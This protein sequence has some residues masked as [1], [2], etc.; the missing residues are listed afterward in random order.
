MRFIAYALLS[1]LICSVA[2]V[3]AASLVTPTE[4]DGHND[5][6]FLFGHWHTHYRI[7]RHRL[8]HDNTWDQ[9]DGDATITAFWDH[10]GNLEVGTLRCPPPRGYVDSMTLRT[11]SADTHQWSLYW[12]TKKIGLSTSPQVGHFDNHGV[13]N[14]YDNDTFN[15]KPIAIRYHWETLK[16]LPHFE[17]A[18]SDDDGKTWETNWICDYTHA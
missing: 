9:C 6:N 13:G 15:G 14:F 16:G 8:T 12:G 10:Y 17:Q 1:I 18:Y 11:Y 4:R 7:L 3:S 2:P 5:F